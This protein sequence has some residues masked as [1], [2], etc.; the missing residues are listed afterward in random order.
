MGKSTLDSIDEYS[1]KNVCTYIDDYSGKMC[2][3]IRLQLHSSG[4]TIVLICPMC[5][6]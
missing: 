4:S 5:T 2:V 1:E 3:P 6:W